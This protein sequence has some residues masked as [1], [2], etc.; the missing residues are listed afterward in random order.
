[1]QRHGKMV[2]GAKMALVFGKNERGFTRVGVVVSKKV[3]KRAVVR[4][5][6]RRRV[7]EAVRVNFENVPRKMDYIIMVYSAEVA[8]MP[9][10]ELEKLVGKLVVEAKS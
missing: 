5:R 1:M 6:I 2:R 8:T 9:F 3:D 7:Y 4:N 10:S